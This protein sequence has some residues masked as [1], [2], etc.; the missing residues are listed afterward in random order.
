[1]GFVDLYNYYLLLKYLMFKYTLIQKFSFNSKFNKEKIG[2]L[3]KGNLYL[4]HKHPLVV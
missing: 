4:I 1:M 2:Q 3:N